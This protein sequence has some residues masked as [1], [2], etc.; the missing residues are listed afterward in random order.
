MTPIPWA[1]LIQLI[2]NYGAPLALKLAEKWS[3]SEPVSEAEMAEL[4][5]LAANTP[6]SQMIARLS[7]A[8]I[9]LDSP[10]AQAL[11]ALLPPM[12]GALPGPS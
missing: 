6:R 9:A 5:E 2:L 10:E 7:A 8:K 4:R 1:T 3:S 12:P 11:L